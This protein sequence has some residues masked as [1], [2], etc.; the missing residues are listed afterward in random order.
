[1]CARIASRYEDTGSGQG[2][3]E[4]GPGKGFEEDAS[5]GEVWRSIIAAK[6]S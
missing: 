5:G 4:A 2:S 3:E 6:R 1:V